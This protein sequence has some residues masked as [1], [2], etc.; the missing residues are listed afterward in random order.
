MSLSLYPIIKQLGNGAFGKTFLSTNTLMPSHPYCVIKQL[1]PT[2]TDPNSYSLIQEQFKKEGLIL[3]KLGEQRNG[4]IPKLY[5]YFVEDGEFYL[6]QEYIGGE[7]LLDRVKKYGQFTEIRVRQLLKDILPV[8]TYVHNQ[9]VVHRDIQPKNIILREGTDQ[10]VLIDFGAVKETMGTTQTLSGNTAKSVIVGTPGFMPAE[11]MSGR[12]MFVSDIYALGLTSIYLL[13]GKMPEEMDSDPSTGQV[14]WQKYA[15]NL[16]PQ[17]M[18][19][20][21]TAIHSVPSSRHNGA[22]DMLIA[23]GE[24]MP[25]DSFGG[26]PAA[27]V[28]ASSNYLDP[29]PVTVVAPVS[30][31]YS[32][33][34]VSTPPSQYF[35]VETTTLQSRNSLLWPAAIGVLAG[36]LLIAAGL[37][38][39]RNFTE[40]SK[41]ISESSPGAVA[42]KQPDFKPSSE[43]VRISPDTA[44]LK[45]YQLIQNNQ[46]DQSWTDLS[47]SFQGSNLAQG[48]QEYKKW[49]NSVNRIDIGR[50]ETVDNSVSSAVVK[51]D[52]SYTLKSGRVMSDQKKYIYLVWDNDKWLINGKSETFRK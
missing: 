50:V 24:A 36:G 33:V 25:I 4:M 43:P 40:P 9:N 35:S 29:S 41:T 39:G 15:P 20:L 37:F 38:L 6:V 32:T 51:A 52:L 46:L 21:N 5:A 28:M 14:E 27:T 44:I 48:F 17:L 2:S 42:T 26:Q 22:K 34:P 3:E 18:A 11:Q 12:P 8:L 1:I 13:T 19:V 7:T 31:G 47:T 49:W 30:E 45:H 16:S 10:P 23:L